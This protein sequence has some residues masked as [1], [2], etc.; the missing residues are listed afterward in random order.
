MFIC[1]QSEDGD[2]YRMACL[3]DNY[4]VFSFFKKPG[5]TVEKLNTVKPIVS[6]QQVAMAIN[7]W[8]T[9]IQNCLAVESIEGRSGKDVSRKCNEYSIESVDARGNSYYITVKK[10]KVLGDTFVLSEAEYAVAQRLGE[11]YKVFV[12]SLDGEK[13]EYTYIDNPVATVNLD[14]VVKEWEFICNTYNTPS[15]PVTSEN[16]TLIDQRIMKNILPEYFNSKQK[17]FLIDFVELGEMQYADDL[18]DMVEKI[19]SVIDFY[20]GM[21]LLEIREEKE[22]Q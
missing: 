9:P 3:A 19:N 7:K 4:P 12:I 21:T 2:F 16:D 15:K 20:T 1:T 11:S 8:K 13:V 6:P 10:V 5:V 14:K 18:S 22:H 17:A